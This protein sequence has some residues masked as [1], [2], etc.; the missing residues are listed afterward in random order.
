[1]R[2]QGR[3]RT[4]R[5]GE[6]LLTQDFADVHGIRVG[7]TDSLAV[8]VIHIR[9]LPTPRKS[10]YIY[11]L[12]K[13]SGYID[14]EKF[15]LVVVNRIRSM[16]SIDAEETGYYSIK[17]QQGQFQR[18]CGRSSMRNMWSQAIWRQ[19][20]IRESPCRSTRAM[21]LRTWRPCTRRSCSSSLSL[22]RSL[23]SLEEISDRSSICWAAF[24]ALGFSREADHRTLCAVWADCQG[25]VGS[26]YLDLD[27]VH[28]VDPGAVSDSISNMIL[29]SLCI[30][31][32]TMYHR[33]L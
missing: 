10:D 28:P 17:Y 27:C 16:I 9:C 13:L 32:P 6:T 3:A 15:A 18:R 26:M 14:S 12:E 8:I 7:D 22:H 4:G 25:V 11:M 20:P 29:K 30:H 21:P 33:S 5:R 24:L 23:W 2:A 31:R 19:P 1:M